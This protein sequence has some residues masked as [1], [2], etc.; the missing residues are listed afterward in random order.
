MSLKKGRVNLF[1][2]KFMRFAINLAMNR[3][4]LTGTNPS[5]GC[6]VVKDK[7]IISYAAT[8]LNGRP[9]AETIAL[10]KCKNNSSEST[11][12]LTLE[13]CSHYG[14]T[15]PCTNKIIQSKVKKV[16]YSVEDSDLRSFNNSK[17]ILK[18]KKIIVKSGLLQNYTQR[19]Y[20]NYD[21]VRKA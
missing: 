2:N 18:S 10:N 21:Y 8:N 13:P 5:V 4:G 12:Y 17:K 3:K 16:Y 15:P 14:K 9:H 6:V 19:F 11:I 1:D 7:K 20:K